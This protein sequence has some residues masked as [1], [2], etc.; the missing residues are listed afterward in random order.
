[1]NPI[2]GVRRDLD[3]LGH[4][5]ALVGGHAVSVLSQPRFTKDLDLAVAVGT[6]REAET[7]LRELQGLDYRVMQVFEHEPTGRLGTARLTLPGTRSAEPELDLLFASSGIEPEVVAAA[8]LLEIEHGVSVPVVTRG[9]L[10]AL[11]TLS[12]DPDR[13]PQDRTDCLALLKL[14]TPDDIASARSALALIT[15]RGFHRG[16]NLS[17]ELEGLLH[18]AGR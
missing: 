11:K 5:W 3:R 2:A 6:D 18:A 16:K 4:R 7:L 8:K 1:L 15:Q 17:H 10:I 14:A 12:A 13:R 9:H